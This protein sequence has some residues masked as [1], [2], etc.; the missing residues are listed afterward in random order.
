MNVL[1]VR[2]ALIIITLALMSLGLYSMYNLSPVSDKR[3]ELAS[4]LDG[5]PI[6]NTVTSTT[7]I[8]S[9]VDRFKAL[10]RIMKLL[11]P[12]SK[13]WTKEYFERKFGIKIPPPSISEFLKRKE[14]S[15]RSLLTLA[16]GW[17]YMLNLKTWKVG[18]WTDEIEKESW[19]NPNIALLTIYHVFR[20]DGEYLG[21]VVDIIIHANCTR[22]VLGWFKMEVKP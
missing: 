1:K 9:N 12:E 17:A 20:W 18:K 3:S 19:R 14:H 13:R 16:Y 4:T 11:F 22:K 8:S 15:P 2:G 10:E 21:T 5:E 6:K 7:T